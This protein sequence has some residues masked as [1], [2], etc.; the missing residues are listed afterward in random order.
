MSQSVDSMLGIINNANQTATILD[1][2]RNIAETLRASN[3][4]N[5]SSILGGISS[6]IQKTDSLIN[7]NNSFAN[8]NL[9]TVGASLKDLIQTTGNTQLS[10]TERNGSLALSAIESVNSGLSHAIERN[11][12]ANVNA[13]D[14][15]GAANLLA[16]ERIGGNLSAI[17]NQNNSILMNGIKESQVTSER[18]FGETRLFNANG[19]QNLERRVGDYY[20]QSEKNFGRVESDLV[21]VENSIGRLVDNHHNAAMI[22]LL[23]THAALDKS[24]DRN[25]LQITRQASDN[26][27]NIQIEAAK[28]KSLLEQKI[29]DI[30]NDI[31]L[32]LLKDNS[33]TRNL[34]N[35]YNNDNLR[36]DLQ[37]ERIIHALHHHHNHHNHHYDRDFYRSHFFPYPH[38]PHNNNNNTP[39]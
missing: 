6:E 28:N 30:G 25:E 19:L 21:R 32:T 14:R 22:E 24:I 11:G 34:I 4:R 29:A 10:A 33:D 35:S 38:F 37:S 3:E 31:K 12:G 18:N 27:A 26:Y 2:Q 1:A 15:N 8:Q 23:K 17:A 16:T 36:N 7:M 9:S 13:T 5:L 20:L 39:N